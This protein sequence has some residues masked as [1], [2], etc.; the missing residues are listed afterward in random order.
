MMVVMINTSN[1]K[2]SQQDARKCLEL[3]QT[4]FV[5]NMNRHKGI[6]WESVLEKLMAQANKLWSLYQ[7]EQ[8]GGEPDVIGFDKKTQEYIFCDCSAESP[9]DRRSV[10][11]DHKA[12]VSRKEHPP[13]N[14]AVTFAESMGIKILDEGEYRA[15][16]KV[17]EFDTKTSSWIATPDAIRSLGGAVFA[18]RRYNTVFVY[19]N[20]ADS[21][22]AARG[23]R[24]LVRV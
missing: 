10:C 6:K 13:K 16:Q 8:T 5:K 15:L 1:K 17:G 7:M 9:K 21:Y 3:L 4:R 20:G 24:G 19:H 23:F 14:S 11:Y 12:L 2:L 18:D 22:Y